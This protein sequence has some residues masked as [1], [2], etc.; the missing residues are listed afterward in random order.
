MSTEYLDWDT[1]EVTKTV[2]W[3]ANEVTETPVPHM[4][5]SGFP[6]IENFVNENMIKPNQKA[7]LGVL[8]NSENESLKQWLE[9][10]LLTE[11]NTIKI[12]GFKSRISRATGE[13]EIKDL[14]RRIYPWWY[15][16]K[17]QK[18]A[19]ADTWMWENV[20]N[21]ENSS[22]GVWISEELGDKSEEDQNWNLDNLL[23]Q[24][25]KDKQ[26]AAVDTQQAAVDTQQAAVDTQQ[27]A[28][29]TQ[30]AAV[31]TQQAAVDT[32]QEQEKVEKV[33]R[34]I[35]IVVGVR[36]DLLK[37]RPG[38][39]AETR[40][41]AAKVR[42]QLPEQTRKYLVDKGYNDNDINN[43]I[44]LRVTINAVRK[45]PSFDKAAVD[46]F[47]DQV[48]K[49]SSLDILLKN[50]DN[51]CKIADTR[52][53]NFD[54]KDIWQTR[55]ELFHEEVWN[56]SLIKARKDNMESHAEAYDR[57]FPEMWEDDMFVK[58]GKFLEWNSKNY[59]NQ[60]RDNYPWFMDK[61][62]SLREQE[63][64]WQPLTEEEKEILSLPWKIKWIKEKMDS[65]TK[66][67]ME[68]LC[69]MSQIKWM[70]MC[71]W[72]WADFN[73]NKANQ[74]KYD[75]KWAM[76]LDGNVGGLKFS[77][78]QDIDDP[79]AKLQTSQKLSQD[80]ENLNIGK[81]GKYVDSN[82]VLPTQE[83]LFASIAEIVQSDKSLDG[84]DKSLENSGSQADYLE[85]LQKKIMENID[86]KFV[87]TKFVH[88]YMQEQVTWEEIVDETESFI[89][90]IKPDIDFTK[91]I[92]QT[93][94]Y[95]DLYPFMKIL[96]FNIDNSTNVE[97]SKLR[98]SISK[99]SEI[100][101]NHKDNDGTYDKSY[102]YP[103]IIEDHLRTG[104]WKADWNEGFWL[105]SRLFKYYC[106]KADDNRT[107]N[108]GYDSF[109]SKVIINDLYR[110]LFEF[111][112]W[113]NKSQTAVEWGN[114][115]KAKEKEEQEKKAK[116]DREQQ[117]SKDIAQADYDLAKEIEW[118][119]PS[120]VPP[121][122]A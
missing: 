115:K 85:S 110:D 27:A 54:L 106:E 37:D 53:K 114:E 40:K 47:E 95:K 10:F 120:P 71:M 57:V 64:Q 60:Y 69:I 80:G 66:D 49:L 43:Y 48:N 101:N 19:W 46:N 42:E 18:S 103:A 45:D 55:T 117:T 17:E 92:S 25:I 20:W 99:I 12:N 68:E 2:D 6:E 74:I 34:A 93:S 111:N 118:F 9:N 96:K 38:V 97:R 4:E 44:L 102:T 13:E 89:K 33:R 84:S 108:D 113:E 83:E 77:I 116:E 59:W 39:D 122:M 61:L 52:A 63:S 82:Y 21:G 105:L 76:I 119:P 112:N 75:E 56:Q 11:T 15:K 100:V 24:V 72:E 36:G 62:Y 90:K 94:D 87:E 73:L 104:E 1:N 70:F 58:Y 121:M 26:Q 30:Q 35:E 51:S 29:D 5:V 107:N 88:D 98:D 32:Q 67:M 81:E 86:K 8:N 109:T 28:V 16:L 14:L 65:D 23:Q 22:E 7:I 79:K 41:E 78:R 31:D 91:S 50:I 3:D